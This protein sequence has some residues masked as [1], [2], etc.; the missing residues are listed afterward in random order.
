MACARSVCFFAHQPDELRPLPPGLPPAELC[1]GTSAAQKNSTQ[2]FTAARVGVSVVNDRVSWAAAPAVL[3][4]AAAGSFASGSSI[5]SSMTGMMVGPDGSSGVLGAAQG[6]NVMDGSHQVAMAVHDPQGDRAV[7][8]THQ[9]QQFYPTA[10]GMAAAAQ[11]QQQQPQQAALMQ[12]VHGS[13]AMLLAAGAGPACIPAGYGGGAAA[14][15]V[16]YWQ[17]V[18]AGAAAPH[19]SGGAMMLGGPPVGYH[20]QMA[21]ADYSGPHLL[22]PQLMPMQ[23]LQL[24]PAQALQQQMQQMQQMQSSLP[25]GVVQ[26]LQMVPAPL[27]V[28]QLPATSLPV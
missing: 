4:S 18:P 24:V 21:V 1:W 6:L 12:Q 25:T 14:G 16:G 20:Q 15:A 10:A 27:T 9:H 19:P 26:Q 3:P 5:N 23:Q 11:Q 17:A 8:L 28:Q 2:R 13:S 22:A 7:L